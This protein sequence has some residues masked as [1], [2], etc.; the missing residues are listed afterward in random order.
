VSQT[1]RFTVEAAAR[2]AGL[3]ASTLN[4]LRVYGGGPSY[5]KLGR[6]VVYDRND[7]DA[8]LAGMRR[9]STSD[10]CAR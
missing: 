8:W 5:L 7:L 4:K 10:Q 9:A 3:S 1:D 2:Y 6:R